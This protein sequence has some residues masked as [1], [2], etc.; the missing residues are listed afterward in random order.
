L[1]LSPAEIE[2]LDDWMSA[3]RTDSRPALGA[4]GART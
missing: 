4:A 2:A 3:R 1:R